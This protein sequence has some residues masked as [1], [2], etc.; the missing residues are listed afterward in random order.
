MIDQIGSWLDVIYKVLT[1]IF[2]TW[3]YL[4]RKNDKTN[5]R[6][7]SLEETLESRLDTHA[8]RLT[9]IEVD[10]HNTPNHADLGKIYDE[11][12][13]QSETM[14]NINAA[15]TAQAATMRSLESLVNRM[16]GFWRSHD[17]RGQ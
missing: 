6:I 5:Q 9:R 15:V 16:D 4:D 2:V 10:L 3:M 14:A 11:I 13:K 8:E 1:A 12:R 17:T 7:S